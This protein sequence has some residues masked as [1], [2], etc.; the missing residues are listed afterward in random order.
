M[1]SIIATLYGLIADP[2]NLLKLPEPVYN[3]FVARK[4]SAQIKETSAPIKREISSLEDALLQIQT[5]IYKNKPQ[6]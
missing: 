1:F 5:N 3:Y 6:N 2:Q 4:Y